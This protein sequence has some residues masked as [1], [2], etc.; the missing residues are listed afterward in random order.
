M[1][2]GLGV[3][4]MA[5]EGMAANDAAPITRPTP[6][7]APLERLREAFCVPFG[8]FDGESGDLR[9]TPTEWPACQWSR[10]AETC[11]AVGRRNTPA[12]IDE[13]GPLAILAIPYVDDVGVVFVAF[14]PFVLRRIAA[15]GELDSAAR[16]WHAP[17]EE[18]LAWARQQ[19][20]WQPEV[21]GRLADSAHREMSAERRWRAAATEADSLAT[22]LASTYEEISLL[23][24]LTQNLTIARGDEEL[25]AIALRWLAE[26]IPAEGLA[27]QLVRRPASPLDADGSVDSHS[28]LLTHG[29]C[30]VDSYGISCMVAHLDVKAHQRP[31]V[32]NRVLTARPDWPCPEVRQTIVVAM[33]E[34]DNLFGYLAALNHARDEEFG[35]VEASLMNSVAVILGIHS[36]N[37]E[38]YRQ[39][40]EMLAGIVRAL[41]SA[42]DAKDPYTCGHSERVARISVCLARE[43]GLDSK[44]LETI[45]LAGLLH[46][47]GKIGVEDRVLRKPEKLS[48]DEYEHI[49][50]HPEIG[51]RILRDLSKL[52]EVLPVV[53]YHH[54]SWDGGGYPSK[55]GSESIPLSARIVAVADSYDAMGSD[56]PYRKAMP[57]EK[58]DAIFR[59]GAGR[60]WDPQVVD[61]LF[62][63]RDEIR[64]ICRDWGQVTA[65]SSS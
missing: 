51:H 35:T 58:I 64:E 4:K 2:A 52:G 41:T 36:G 12:I 46:D 50:R 62:R 39:Q 38:L 32:A 28:L 34:G 59:A 30:P 16:A 33:A 9:D 56:R 55:L 42:I 14:S 27:I 18:L 40:A 3:G 23:Y 43:L 60:Q 13:T 17:R 5:A 54:E 45:Y 63:V 44:A 22:N 6:L 57:D 48:D 37:I 29:Q 21:L 20:V 26:V 10:W 61:V 47:I 53:L 8:V 49:K 1:T 15:V 25:G 65:L 11:R 31:A 24:R 19:A 7:A